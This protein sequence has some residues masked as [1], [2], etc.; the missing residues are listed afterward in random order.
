VR[1]SGRDAVLSELYERDYS[2]EGRWDPVEI[3]VIL[4]PDSEYSEVYAD[5]LDLDDEAE[6]FLRECFD[7]DVECHFG[8][9]MTRDEVA[10]LLHDDLHFGCRDSVAIHLS[11]NSHEDHFQRCCQIAQAE[12]ARRQ[13]YIAAV[14]QDNGSVAHLISWTDRKDLLNRWCR[15][16]WTI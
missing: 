15:H 2:P 14:G 3:H 4:I 7:S 12:T 1:V 10:A 6:A 13:G 16:L 9:P 8:R 11:K 5:D